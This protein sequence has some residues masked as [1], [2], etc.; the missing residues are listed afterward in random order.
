MNRNTLIAGL[1]VVSLLGVTAFGATGTVGAQ[2][3]SG[4]LETAFGDDGESGVVEAVLATVQGEAERFRY[5]IAH[6]SAPIVGGEETDTASE[7]LEAVQ[8]Y[9]NPRSDNFESWINERST[10]STEYDVVALEFQLG[11]ETSTAYL[12]ADVENES[13]HNSSIVDETNRTV[14]HNVTLCGYAADEAPGELEA[15]YGEYV[16]TGDDV[17][18]SYVGRLAGSY[19]KNV[20]TSLPIGVEGGQGCDA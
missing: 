12:V 7:E 19:R 3:D 9:Y 13:Y 4:P 5:E 11:G 2:S 20:A 14:D 17:D 8:S 10:A 16:E 15:F 18:R 6:S 1:L